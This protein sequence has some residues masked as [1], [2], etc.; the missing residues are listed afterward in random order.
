MFPLT[1]YQ[2]LLAQIDFTAALSVICL[3]YHIL[4]RTAHKKPRNI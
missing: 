1:Q 3:E 2:Y 4:C